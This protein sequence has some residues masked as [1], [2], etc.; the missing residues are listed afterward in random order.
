MKGKIVTVTTERETPRQRTGVIS[1]TPARAVSSQMPAPMPPRVMPTMAE[2]R[3]W[4]VATMML[5]MTRRRLPKMA[6]Q[7][8]PEGGQLVGSCAR[9]GLSTSV[10]PTQVN[11]YLSGL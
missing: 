3:L 2:A 5:E 7:R 4:V 10:R 8:R 11:A 6:I 9:G 1:A